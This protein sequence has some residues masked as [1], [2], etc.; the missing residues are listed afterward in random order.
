LFLRQGYIKCATLL[1]LA[2]SVTTAYFHG[3]YS[4]SHHGHLS[5]ALKNNPVGLLYYTM[6]YLGSPFYYLAGGGSVGKVVATLSCVVL[7]S[8][9]MLM[10][11]KQVFA[12]KKS[13]LI[14]ALMF[15]ILYV[16]GTAFGTAGGRLIFGFDSAVSSRYTTPAIMAW[17][18]LVVALWGGYADRC[19]GAARVPV[20]LLFVSFGIVMLVYQLNALKR[21]DGALSLRE[22]AALAAT[23]GIKDT[24]YIGKLYPDPNHT[25][26]LAKSGNDRVLSIFGKYPYLNLRNEIGAPYKFGDS[27]LCAGS[28]DIAEPIAGVP[29]YF[30]IQGWVFDTKTKRSPKVIRFVNGQGS[31]VGVALTGAPR[32]DVKKLVDTNAGLAGFKG[33]LQTSAAGLAVA[34][35]GD[36]P[37]CKLDFLVPANVIGM[38]Q[39]TKVN[40]AILVPTISTNDVIENSG[41]NGGD[42]QKT[43]FDNLVVYGSYVNADANKGSIK[44]RAS[45][46]DLFYYRSGPTGGRQIL[47]IL[48]TKTEITLPPTLE[49]SALNLS[50]SIVPNKFEIELIDN[51]DSWGEWSAIAIA[52][53]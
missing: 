30:R 23:L 32:D 45:K 51:G 22:T 6:L 35:L 9:S 14:F 36:D 15:Y 12:V 8:L 33:Y 16:G 21:I 41:F 38:S 1:V 39:L 43:K 37:G 53:K 44:F 50:N 31:L 46:G 18:A 11:Y 34:A 26:A 28:L 29:D 49:W 10:A 24:E 13:A 19:K 2:I 47:K 20:Q 48:N 25:L 7:A 4:P 42:Y 5:D 17:A 27:H 40:D 3:Y 52:R